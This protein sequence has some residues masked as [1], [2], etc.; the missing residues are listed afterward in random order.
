EQASSPA[1][2]LVRRAPAHRATVHDANPMG[3]RS[4]GARVAALVHQPGEDPLL[5]R[6]QLV[7]AIERSGPDPCPGFAAVP[8]PS[9]SPAQGDPSARVSA[10]R[11]YRGRRYAARRAALRDWGWGKVSGG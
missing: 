8:A 5:L 9:L 6:D 2:V 1:G 10:W 7:V 3:A 4:L 11:R